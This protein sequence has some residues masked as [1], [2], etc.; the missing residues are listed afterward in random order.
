MKYQITFILLFALS[1]MGFSQTNSVKGTIADNSGNEL[2]GVNVLI[3]NTSKGAQTNENGSFEIKN[4]E[5]GDF[6]LLVSYLGFKT[7]EVAFSVNN[8]TVNLGTI[9]L[10]EGNELL[11]EVVID[12]KRKNKF[13]RKQSAL[14]FKNAFKEHRKLSSLQYYN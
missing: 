10:Y 7:K 9:T 3:K 5:N 2:I 8:Q 6:T 13:S 12:S 1:V 14:C 11:Q 4:L